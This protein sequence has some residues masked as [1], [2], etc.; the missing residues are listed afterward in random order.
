MRI[1]FPESEECWSWEIIGA[2]FSSVKALPPHSNTKIEQIAIRV[3]APN[4]DILICQKFV[5]PRL[6]E[7]E[8]LLK[9]VAELGRCVSSS[10]RE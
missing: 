9:K 1:T 3:T 4:V 8:I 10:L 5:S 2:S 6:I 7:C